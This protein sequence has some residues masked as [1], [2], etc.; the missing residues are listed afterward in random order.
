VTGGE[1]EAVPQQAVAVPMVDRQLVAR[2]LDRLAGTLTP[3]MLHG[4]ESLRSW[5]PRVG[6][7]F[8]SREVPAGELLVDRLRA[9]LPPVISGALAGILNLADGEL[10]DACAV[11][12]AE[13]GAWCLANPPLT[14]AQLAAAAP[15]LGHLL[16]S[17]E[18]PIVP[19]DWDAVAD[20]TVL[21]GTG[22]SRET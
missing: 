12:A 11:I 21:N 20:P 17:L 13:L 18:E 7:G 5:R 6:V 16:G 1:L 15:A 19:V 2:D 10:R 3:L 22:V 8:L 4:M 9:F 14:D